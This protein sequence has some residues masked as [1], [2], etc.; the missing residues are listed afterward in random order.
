MQRSGQ[1]LFEPEH[2]VQTVRGTQ[3]QLREANVENLLL[4]QLILHRRQHC[5]VAQFLQPQRV[6]T[7]L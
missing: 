6:Q 5:I 3:R 4:R 2:R 1:H 7:L